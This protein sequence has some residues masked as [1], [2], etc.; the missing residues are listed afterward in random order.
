VLGIITSLKSR[1]VSEEWDY[2]VWLLQRTLDSILAQT[3]ASFVV[4]VVCH[5]IPRISHAEHAKVRFLSVDFPPPP[6]VEPF[7][8]SLDK[9]FKLSVGAE[10]AIRN[11]CDYVMFNDADDLVHRRMSEFVET[12]S[13]ANGWYSPTE[14]A[15]AYGSRWIR[16]YSFPVQPGP[17]VITR[18]SLLK[19]VKRHVAGLSAQLLLYGWDA[20]DMKMLIG[21]EF[22]ILAAVGHTNYQKFMIAEGNPLARLPFPGNVMINHSGSSSTAPA[23]AG[24]ALWA[25]SQRRAGLRRRLGHVKRIAPH[26]LSVRPLTRALCDDFAIPRPNT[27][28]VAYT[29]K[30]TIFSR[31]L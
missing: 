7:F 11:G 19:F 28:P 30:G 18:S 17:C 23:Q 26:L 25:T 12:H 3:S 24:D 31:D 27:I 8:L 14:F 1:V 4:A 15:Y 9:V 22:C 6:F 16:K 20:Q 2:D 13:G 5:E 21:R 10:W 29:K